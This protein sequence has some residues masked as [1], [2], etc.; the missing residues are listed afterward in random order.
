MPSL[1]ARVVLFLS[2]YGPLFLIFSIQYYPRYRL[3][4]LLPLLIGGCAFLG[5][6]FFIRWVRQGAPCPLKVASVQRKD[7]EV[8][9]YMFA[10]VFPFLGLNVADVASVVS[11]AVFFLVLLVLNVSS[12]MVHINPALNLLRYHVDEV[13]TAEGHSHTL[14]SRRGRLVAGTELT[15]VPIG[16]DISMEV[17]RATR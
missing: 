17:A 16:D 1:L 5:L 13:S 4:A 14:L 12:N 9:A 15:V 11:L 7:A 2:G 8:I 6:L 3:W 10:Y